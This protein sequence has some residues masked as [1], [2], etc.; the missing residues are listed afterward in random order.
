[1]IGVAEVVI[2]LLIAARPLSPRASAVGSVGAIFMFAT[3]LSFMATTPGSWAV[4]DGFFVPANAGSFLIKD[5]L[6]LG[7]AIWSAGEA[8]MASKA[9]A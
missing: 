5:L 4:V 1:V 6:L 8:M 9:G 2:A 7:A 3:T